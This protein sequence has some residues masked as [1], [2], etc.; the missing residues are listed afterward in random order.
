MIGHELHI[1][2]SPV[3][4]GLL[5]IQTFNCTIVNAADINDQQRK[6]PHTGKVC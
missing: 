6:P 2:P 4:E 5:V 3:Q 1:A